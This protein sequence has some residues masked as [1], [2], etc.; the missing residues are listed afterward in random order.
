V[1]K[2]APPAGPTAPG[3]GGGDLVHDVIEMFDGTVIDDR[4]S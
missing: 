3:A 2:A 4:E 1:R